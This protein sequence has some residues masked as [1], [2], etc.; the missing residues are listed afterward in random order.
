MRGLF[1]LFSRPAGGRWE[2]RAGVMRGLSAP[3]SL[4]N[5]DDTDYDLP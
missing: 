4:C 5:P 1:S 2:K 3:A